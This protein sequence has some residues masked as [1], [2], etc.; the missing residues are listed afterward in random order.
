MISPLEIRCE[1]G[2]RCLWLSGKGMKEWVG[3]VGGGGN[4]FQSGSVLYGAHILLIPDQQYLG[5]LTTPPPYFACIFVNDFVPSFVS[6]LMILFH[7]LFPPKDLPVCGIL[8]TLGL[9]SSVILGV[10]LTQL[11]KSTAVKEAGLVFHSMESALVRVCRLCPFLY[12][13]PLLSTKFLVF[14]KD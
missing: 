13:V 3:Q 14:F 10:S 6:L 1:G 4:L 7:H 11:G 12:L 5:H 9:L 2:H 8:S